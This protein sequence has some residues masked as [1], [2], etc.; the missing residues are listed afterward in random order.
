[1]VVN[2]PTRAGL[3]RDLYGDQILRDPGNGIIE[4]GS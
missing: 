3:L 1:M 4:G 2:T